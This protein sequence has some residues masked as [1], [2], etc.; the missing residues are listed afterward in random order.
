LEE[1]VSGM[2]WGGRLLHQEAEGNVTL[3]GVLVVGALDHENL[4]PCSVDETESAPD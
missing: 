4:L 3:L 2:T 1:R